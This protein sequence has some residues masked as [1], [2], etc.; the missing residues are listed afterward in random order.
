MTTPHY[1]VKRIK[2][3]SWPL[4]VIWLGGGEVHG[5]GVR[6]GSRL[7][8]YQ[9]KVLCLIKYPLDWLKTK[10]SPKI[11]FLPLKNWF[12]VVW[13]RDPDWGKN[14]GSRSIKNKSGS[15]TLP[16]CYT[17]SLLILNVDKS[18]ET[19]PWRAWSVWLSRARLSKSSW[20]VAAFLFLTALHNPVRS[21]I[22][23]RILVLLLKRN[24]TYVQVSSCSSQLY[25]PIRSLIGNLT[26][27]QPS[28]FP[29]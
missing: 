26:S 18:R 12:F 14:P 17:S 7:L 28:M 5:I 3:A 19:V 29:S 22:G 10:I 2:S 20:T 25:S 1:T 13:I 6:H 21:L 9:M 24:I 15:E 8:Q 23:N 27:L 4:A 11:L 16:T